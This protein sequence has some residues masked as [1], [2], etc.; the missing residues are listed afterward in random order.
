MN[1]TVKK[2]TKTWY[3]RRGGGGGAWFD[4]QAFILPRCAILHTLFSSIPSFFSPFLLSS[5]LFLYTLFHLGRSTGAARFV[6]RA[7]RWSTKVTLTYTI[8]HLHSHQS[9]RQQHQYHISNKIQHYY[10]P[11]TTHLRGPRWRHTNH[12]SSLTWIWY[13][14]NIINNTLRNSIPSVRRNQYRLWEER[15]IGKSGCT[16]LILDLESYDW[17]VACCEREEMNGWWR[18]IRFVFCCSFL[19]GSITAAT[20][21]TSSFTPPPPRTETT[22]RTIREVEDQLSPYPPGAW[23][24]SSRMSAGSRRGARVSSSSSYP[25]MPPSYE[26]R[27]GIKRVMFLYMPLSSLHLI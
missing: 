5:F 3:Q 2:L 6:A 9:P 10:L 21:T 15:I 14:S 25:L 22:R 17:V 13:S 19:V 7:P 18:S 11:T 1:K 27:M 20:L 16:L 8:P 24:S 4:L 12:P 26:H 23:G